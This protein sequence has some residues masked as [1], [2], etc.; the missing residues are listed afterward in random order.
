MRYVDTIL[1]HP[2]PCTASPNPWWFRQTQSCRKNISDKPYQKT[3]TDKV[4]EY[5]NLTDNRKIDFYK[6]MYAESENRIEN[7]KSYTETKILT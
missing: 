6:N 5:K 7:Q 1:N 2:N 4:L 3:Y